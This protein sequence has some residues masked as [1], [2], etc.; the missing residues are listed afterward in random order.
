MTL[1][2]VRDATDDG[3]TNSTGGGSSMAGWT[4]VPEIGT[5]RKTRGRWIGAARPSKEEPL[6]CP[7]DGSRGASSRISQKGEDQ[8]T[9]TEEVLLANPLQGHRGVLPELYQLSE[10]EQ[11][12][13]TPQSTPPSTCDW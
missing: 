6:S 13:D 10:V 1:Q 3:H 4:V 8:A 2:K 12:Q 9:H 11:L 7:E 5:P